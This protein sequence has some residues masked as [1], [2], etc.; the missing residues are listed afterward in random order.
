[1]ARKIRR[2]ARGEVETGR[3]STRRGPS[4]PKKNKTDQAP[5]WT[6]PKTWEESKNQAA[7]ANVRMG[8]K[9]DKD[10][11]VKLEKSR[12]K[13]LE[14]SGIATLADLALFQQ[15]YDLSNDD[16]IKVV[17]N[18]P[19][20]KKQR[21][22]FTRYRE[23]FGNKDFAPT[24]SSGVNPEIA[25]I[26]NIAANFA[27]PSLYTEEQED[28]RKRLRSETEK[29]EAMLDNVMPLGSQYNTTKEGSGVSGKKT[30]ADILYNA[31]STLG[32][33]SKKRISDY[34]TK[35]HNKA[36]E[37]ILSQQRSGKKTSKKSPI[38]EIVEGISGSN[39]ISPQDKQDFVKQISM[40]P[41]GVVTQANRPST[42]IDNYDAQQKEFRDAQ[43]QDQ[44]NQAQRRME[45]QQKALEAISEIAPTLAQTGLQAYRQGAP[46]V[47]QFGGPTGIPS[48]DAYDRLI[49]FVRPERTGFQK[50]MAAYSP[51][52]SQAGTAIGG[53]FGGP[54]GAAGG[55]VG[56]LGL[57]SLLSRLGQPQPELAGLGG[58]VSGIGQWVTGEQ[59]KRG[60][61][62]RLLGRQAQPTLT[63][64]ARG[65]I[66]GGIEGAGNW[67]SQPG[68]ADQL[69]NALIGYELTAS[70]MNEL[71][72]GD[73]LSRGIPWLAEKVGLIS[74]EERYLR[75][76]GAGTGYG[77]AASALPAA[78]QF[79]VPELQRQASDFYGYQVPANDVVRGLD[80]QLRGAIGNQMVEQD[81]KQSQIRSKRAALKEKNRALNIDAETKRLLNQLQAK[82][83]EDRFQ[84]QLLQHELKNRESLERAKI[85]RSRN[86]LARK[87]MLSN[88]PTQPVLPLERI[89]QPEQA[90]V[91]EAIDQLAPYVQKAVMP[92]VQSK[93]TEGLTK[94]IG[95]IP[96]IT[97]TK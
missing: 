30:E 67:L 1:M 81:I 21:D 62:D 45:Q 16:M 91:V 89:T 14:K 43:V 41:E 4:I 95:K 74:P 55:Y 23:I 71:G 97:K 76:V 34:I 59:P 24:P 50:A 11:R 96:D 39:E 35:N 38:K 69:R 27:D 84:R 13:D 22:A 75:N 40:T 52:A 9:V 65:T 78:L 37:K 31:L 80:A 5:S 48:V 56:G 93:I 12:L 8:I 92:Y 88:L 17:Q 87:E 42:A 15:E 77:I 20:T 2:N 90:G 49:N 10:R 73:K 57:G 29:E 54:V 72:I 33:A 94:D 26:Y 28:A 63:Q 83:N 51:Y 66:G 32:T 61:I 64:R 70:L 68:R 18:N 79:A 3:V 36:V 47:P 25:N 53:A 46:Q 44:L 82:Q 86:I 58:R 60:L 85:N 7:L 6:P 19:Q